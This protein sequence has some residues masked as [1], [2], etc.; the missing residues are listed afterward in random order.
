MNKG[1][2]IFKLYRN[3]IFENNYR[4]LMVSSYPVIFDRLKNYVE[5]LGKSFYFTYLSGELI[6]GTPI[7]EVEYD[8]EL[9]TEEKE[10]YIEALKKLSS[11]GEV[12]T[13]ESGQIIKEESTLCLIKFVKISENIELVPLK[14]EKI[15]VL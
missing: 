7:V 6:H 5:G 13:T 15:K 4:N 3:Q 14:N 12:F 1:V 9:S 8:K 11:E 2:V 10:F